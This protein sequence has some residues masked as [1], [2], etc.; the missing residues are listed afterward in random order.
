M[1]TRCRPKH[2][3][4]LFFALSIYIHFATVMHL[5]SKPSPKPTT[6]FG[7]KL[8]VRTPAPLATLRLNRV[9]KP[10]VPFDWSHSGKCYK[11]RAQP[12]VLIKTAGGP[13][14]A[15]PVTVLDRDSTVAA[16]PPS[17]CL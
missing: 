15:E 3:Q 4:F 9:P 8:R 5:R 13:C 7:Q 2:T 17:R 6:T 10:S 14:R 11:V 16:E 12:L 1:Y